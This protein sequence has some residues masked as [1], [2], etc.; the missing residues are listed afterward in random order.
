V[1][2]LLGNT[3][4]HQ[5]PRQSSLA[6]GYRAQETM[7]AGANQRGDHGRLTKAVGALGKVVVR[8]GGDGFSLQVEA[9]GGGAPQ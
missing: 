6:R 2:A 9:D 5:G 7:G 1:V 3:A 4:V 8:A